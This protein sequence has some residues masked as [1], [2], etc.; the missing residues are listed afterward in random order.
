MQG[1]APAARLPAAGRRLCTAKGVTFM[2]LEDETGLSNVIAWRRMRG[3][4]RRAV[5]AG[6]APRLTGRV[7]RSG[8]ATRATA[9]KIEDIS[10]TLDE[11]PGRQ[12]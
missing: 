6:R 7:E 5:I 2:T 12:A 9:G 1:L 4:F 10:R 8:G 11:L 3:R